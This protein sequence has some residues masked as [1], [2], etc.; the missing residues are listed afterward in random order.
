VVD[1]S[2]FVGR[3]VL[4]TGG[5]GFLGSHLVEQLVRCGARVTVLDDLSAGSEVNLAPAREAAT[6]SSAWLTPRLVTGCVTA[7]EV[8]A[9]L[10]DAADL[11]FHLAAVVGVPAALRD[12]LWAMRV[13]LRGSE[14]VFE[15]AA[16]AGVPV[17]WTSSSEVYGD[18][19]SAAGAQPLRGFQETDPLQVGPTQDPRGAYACSKALAEWTA[20]ALAE[21]R[22]LQVL[23]LRL[24]NVVGPRQAARSGMVLPRF[25]G[26]ALRGEALTVYGDGQ[27]TRCFA[28]V[29]DVVAM[30]LAL[31]GAQRPPYGTTVNV[32]ADR[33]LRILDLAHQVAEQLGA[34][35]GVR[36][37]P[38]ECAVDERSR[39][40]RR[41]RPDLARLTRLLGARPPSRSLVET[42]RAVAEQVPAGSCPSHD[43]VTEV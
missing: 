22:G 17:V 2:R 6:A 3:S 31:S 41:R 21:A 27:Q 42:I 14:A 25:V 35:G 7:P 40:R 8:V 33:E 9:P 5:A 12:P 11:V 4:V 1:S 18:G 24:F 38:F 16:G 13:N 26:Q 32:G 43:T 30:I 19:A 37:V 20:G 23:T 28:D 10:V 29:R 36:F 39:D 15:A 34:P